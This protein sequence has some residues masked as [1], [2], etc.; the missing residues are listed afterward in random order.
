MEAHLCD[1]IRVVCKE[2]FFGLLHLLYLT[3]KKSIFD[4]QEKKTI[5]GRYNPTLKK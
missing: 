2:F 1:I 4:I 5:R 3:R